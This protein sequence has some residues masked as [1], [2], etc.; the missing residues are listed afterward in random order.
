M[1]KIIFI[2]SAMVLALIPC[3]NITAQNTK[4]ASNKTADQSHDH[5]EKLP[6]TTYNDDFEV[7]AEAIPF[8][9]GEA[10]SILGHFTFLSNYKPLEKGSVTI[11]M[12]VGTKEVKQTL[13]NPTR[14]GIYLFNLTPP[15]SGKGKIAFEIQTAKGISRLVVPDVMVYTN[16]EDAQHAAIS[17]SNEGVNGVVFIKEKSW[18]IDFAT[19][20]VTANLSTKAIT[21]PNSAIVEEKGKSFVYVQITPEYFE[22]REIKKGSTS[23]KSTVV[24][25]GITNNQRIITKGTDKVRIHQAKR[26]LKTKAG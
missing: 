6:L 1:K 8:V 3:G 4:A 18:K 9:A 5:N 25:E 26:E 14:T 17:A 22:K 13:N 15:V 16:K 11:S 19:E 24:L 12:T 21:I 10:S 2:F 20:V 23:G 7:F